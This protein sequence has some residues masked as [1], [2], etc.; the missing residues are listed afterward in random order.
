MPR[1]FVAYRPP[2]YVRDALLDAMQSVEGA[3]WQDDDQLHLTLRFIGDVDLP[4]AEDIAAMVQSLSGAAI[5]ACV[6]GVGTFERKGRTDNLHTRVGPREPLAALHRKV[7]TA[8]V[9]LGLKPE[10]RAYHPHITLARLGR[11]ASNVGGW[12]TLYATLSAPPFVVDHLA[13]F[14][15]H[16]GKAGATYEELVRADLRARA[17]AA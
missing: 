2:P 13:L 6:E 5:P 9:R 1:L 14:E 8:L 10:G 3:R 16:L 7:D 4:M 15:S 12:I 11:S 17:P